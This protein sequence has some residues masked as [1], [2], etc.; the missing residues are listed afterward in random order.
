MSRPMLPGQNSKYWG[1]DLNN[2]LLDLDRR[3]GLL[4]GDTNSGQVSI[5]P[6]GPGFINGTWNIEGG[7]TT[8][9]NLNAVNDSIKINGKCVFETFRDNVTTYY[10]DEVT[11][12][13]LDLV[14]DIV[15]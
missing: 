12:Y 2:Y 5:R 6:A 11:D 15:K 8:N 4:E 3:V 13:I 14:K 9:I 7:S 10:I 1:F